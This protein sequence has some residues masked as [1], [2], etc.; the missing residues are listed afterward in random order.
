V[1]DAPSRRLPEMAR[2]CMRVGGRHRAVVHITI[3]V[4]T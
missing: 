4:V 3:D 1:L 2:I